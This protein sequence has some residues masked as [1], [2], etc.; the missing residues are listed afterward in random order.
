M[1]FYCAFLALLFA[2][3]WAWAMP[4]ITLPSA[5]VPATGETIIPFLTPFDA[6]VASLP[7]EFQNGWWVWTSLRFS[8]W[9][10]R[11]VDVILRGLDNDWVVR[12]GDIYETSGV[13][14]TF[15]TLDTPAG[16]D[17]AGGGGNAYRV[18]ENEPPRRYYLDFG[19]NGG[20]H[21]LRVSNI[22][23]T[24]ANHSHMLLVI[25]G[26]AIAAASG[27]Y[28]L[29]FMMTG[30]QFR[31]AAGGFV[32]ETVDVRGGIFTTVPEPGS[33]VGICGGLG[34]LIALGAS[35]RRKG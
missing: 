11:Y 19:V 16:M 4:T 27:T 2:A 23:T 21:P 35:R 29:P 34:T 26:D 32:Y 6:D 33:L 30:V 15:V 20:R 12:L 22:W 28:Q 17:P 3:L 1:R 25:H 9:D 7:A 14:S 18:L 5:V 24:G 10:T 8:N 31:N 13:P